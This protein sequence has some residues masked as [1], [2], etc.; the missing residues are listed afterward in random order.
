ML[1]QKQWTD[2]PAQKKHKLNKA[3]VK[4]SGPGAKDFHRSFF[5]FGVAQGSKERIALMELHFYF[6]SFVDAPQLYLYSYLE[7]YFFYLY[8]QRQMPHLY[9]S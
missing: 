3:L 2:G 9:F 1:H 5:V 7:L 4:G 8:F 6:I